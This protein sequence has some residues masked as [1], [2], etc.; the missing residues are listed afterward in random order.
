MEFKLIADENMPKSVIKRLRQS[1]IDIYSI[2]EED[3]GVNDEEIIRLSRENQKSIITMDK[4]FGY[5]TFHQKQHPYCVILFRIHPQ[6]PDII[7]WSIVNVLNL[8]KAQKIDLKHKFIVTDG[9]TL[10]V[11]KF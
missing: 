1:N 7:Y 2:R 8:I 3:K 6:S 5:L 11:R 10:R 4:D 9:K